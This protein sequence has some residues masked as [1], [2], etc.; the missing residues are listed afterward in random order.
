ML[1]INEAWLALGVGS[2]R[3]SQL[4]GIGEWSVLLV[5]ARGCA[6]SRRLWMSQGCPGTALGSP[7]CR[8]CL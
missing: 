5:E 8:G 4:S 3:W 7:C 1:P 6:R 2:S